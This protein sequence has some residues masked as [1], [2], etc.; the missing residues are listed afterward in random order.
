MKATSWNTIDVD[1][2]PNKRLRRFYTQ[3]NSLLKRLQV[4]HQIPSGEE[5][6]ERDKQEWQAS[7]AMAI[8]LSFALNVILLVLKVIAAVASGSMTVIASAADSFLDLISGLVLFVTQWAM[9]K[10]DP[11][12][13]PQGKTRMEPVGVIVFSVVMGLSSLQIVIEAVKRMFDKDPSFDLDSWTLGLLAGTVLSKLVAF[14]L[15]DRVASRAKSSAVE[16]Y[17]SDHRNDVV[18]N[19]VAIGAVVAAYYVNRVWFLDPVGAIGIAL[20]I[21]YNWCKTGFEHAVFLTGRTAPPEFLKELTYIACHHDQRIIAVDT[22]RAYHFGVNYLVEV[23]IVLPADM[24]LR[25][26][27]DIGESLQICLEEL[28]E[29]ERAFVHNDFEWS[30]SPEHKRV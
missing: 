25:E 21:M 15:C 16:A 12:M 28:D 13:Y 26:S 11:S 9:N 30:H 24:P 27:H 8:R 20:W 19:T 17:A 7:I 29:V 23:D 14:W 1:Q 18:T 22:V 10:K 4:Y 6:D 5:A 2:Q 3:Q